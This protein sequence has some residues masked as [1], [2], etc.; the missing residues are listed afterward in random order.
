MKN[1]VKWL[2]IIALVAVIGF[3]MVGCDL[4]SDD[5]TLEGTW[6]G[7]STG[8][9][10]HWMYVFSGSEYILKEKSG[11]SYV[12]ITKC[13]FSLNESKTKFTSNAGGY[14]WQNGSWVSNNY[15]QAVCDIVI[16]GNSFTM[17]GYPGNGWSNNTYWTET[18][19]KQ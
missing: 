9:E 17:T 10:E 13:T 19:T 7:G 2:G 14:K 3:S 5:T 6:I 1:F 4:D 12:N 16:S 18:Y 15:L 8:D 11:S